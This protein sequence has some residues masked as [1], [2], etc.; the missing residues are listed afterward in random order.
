MATGV[1]DTTSLVKLTGWDDGELRKYAL[2]DGT[3]F[4]AIVAML[5][6]ALGA[7]NGEIANDP[8]YSALVSYTDQP[9][10]GRAHV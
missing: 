5:N 9:E 7:V 10:I 8:L 6:G 1:R 4:T 3:N 2:Q